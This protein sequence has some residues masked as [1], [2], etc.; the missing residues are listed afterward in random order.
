MS[1]DGDAIV[2]IETE[3]HSTK[4]H[5]VRINNGVVMMF[6]LP[7]KEYVTMKIEGQ[8]APLIGKNHRYLTKMNK[9]I[10]FNKRIY[11]ASDPLILAFRLVS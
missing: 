4:K 5:D 8:T 6:E 1:L 10:L 9:R 7:K 2:N 11:N 3:C